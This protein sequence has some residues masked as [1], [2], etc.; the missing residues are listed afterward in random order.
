MCVA[1]LKTCLY[2]L[3]EEKTVSEVNDIV[4]RFGKPGVGILYE[5]FRVSTIY[6]Y[7]D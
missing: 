7:I 4:N 3:G 1:E 6:I 5:G 2:S